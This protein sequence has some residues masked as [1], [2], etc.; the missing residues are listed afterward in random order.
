VQGASEQDHA[1]AASK[2]MSWLAL[3]AHGLARRMLFARV[4]KRML[5]RYRRFLIHF[6]YFYFSIV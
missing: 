4:T 2:I 3:I 5:N 6:L 1:G